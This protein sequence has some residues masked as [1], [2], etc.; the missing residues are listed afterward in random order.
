MHWGGEGWGGH[1]DKVLRRW[2]EL[3]LEV[4]KVASCEWTG[5]SKPRVKGEEAWPSGVGG[6]MSLGPECAVGRLEGPLFP[7]ML[8]GPES[9]RG[10]MGG[11]VCG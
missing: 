11:W 4:G 10:Q 7:L 5:D 6:S 2:K 1:G 8:G 9:G 3:D